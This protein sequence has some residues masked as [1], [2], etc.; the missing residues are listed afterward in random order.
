MSTTSK[1]LL[2]ATLALV[3]YSQNLTCQ[4]PNG[5]NVDWYLILKYPGNLTT[6]NPRYAYIDSTYTTGEFSIL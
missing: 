5:T 4:N 3:A 2:F 1:F 6:S